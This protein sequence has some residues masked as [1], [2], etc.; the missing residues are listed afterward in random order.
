MLMAGDTTFSFLPSHRGGARPEKG[1]INERRRDRPG[2]RT[3]SANQPLTGPPDRLLVV[4]VTLFSTYCSMRRKVCWPWWRRL[5]P[6]GQPCRGSSR[7][8]PSRAERP[9]Q[10]VTCITPGEVS[11]VE[12]SKTREGAPERRRVGVR[13]GRPPAGTASLGGYPDGLVTPSSELLT[14]DVTATSGWQCSSQDSKASRRFGGVPVPRR[15]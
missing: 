14:S 4:E 12:A 5:G 3:V 9:G 11:A 8:D 7:R 1:R 2:R 13:P 15:N 10:Y 6:G